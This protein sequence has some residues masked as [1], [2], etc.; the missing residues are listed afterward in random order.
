MKK[1]YNLLAVF[2]LA[3]IFT[4]LFYKK[5]IGLNIFIFESVLILWLLITKQICIHYKNIFLYGSG[6]IITSLFTFLTFSLYSFIINFLVLFVFVG[7]LIYPQAKSVLCSFSLSFRNLFCSQVKFVN[8]LSRLNIKGI[9]LG[10]LV[11]RLSVFIIPL[12]IVIIFTII[13]RNSNPHFEE[14]LLNIGDFLYKIFDF[15]FKDIDF[16][17]FITF[18][19]GLFFSNFFLFR[20]PN[21]KIEG[22]D[23]SASYEL[24]RKKNRT[25]NV[26]RNTSLKREYRAGVFLL[27]TLNVILLVFNTIDINSVWISFIWEGQSLKEF[28]H[29]GTYS[30]IIS[31]LISICIVLYF[32]RGS[33]NFL[34]KNKFL[35]YLSYFWLFQ[36]GILT[37]SVAIRNVYYI[38]YFSL[39]YRR[40]GLAIFLILTIYG[41]YSVYLKVKHKKSAFYLIK[42]NLVALYI[43]LVLSSTINWDSFI[44]KFNFNKYDKSYLHLNFLVTLSDK[45][46]P[47]LDMKLS[48]LIKIDSIQKEIFPF[49][50]N[51]MPPE[52]Y[53]MIIEN[54]KQAFIM[55]W[56]SKKIISW[57]LPEYL[58]YKKLKE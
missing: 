13:Y 24:N 22:Y 52:E 3:V 31:I 18:L 56:E 28:V 11:G 54:R 8:E 30:L 41:L 34:S 47:H 1:N 50:K 7:V 12:I 4:V 5:G 38:N 57:N 36:N 44:A 58:A 14:L 33:I 48:E 32:F 43:A 40:I 10:K 2:I 46:L 21:P 49:I 37:I 29:K 53:H 45:S 55:K 27:V 19:F 15:V 35:K 39:A 17:L 23:L 25:T 20:S 51:T 26:F 16:L 9:S 42:T 6:L